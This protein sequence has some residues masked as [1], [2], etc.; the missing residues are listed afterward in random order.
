MNDIC[1]LFILNQEPISNSFIKIITINS[2]VSRT[3]AIDNFPIFFK[4][5]KINSNHLLTRRGSSVRL[6]IF[7]L[8]NESFRNDCCQKLIEFTN[9]DEELAR[10]ILIIHGYNLDQ[11]VDCVLSMTNLNELINFI[12]KSWSFFNKNSSNENIVQ[13]ATFYNTFGYTN[14]LIE[15]L[16]DSTY[17]K[18]FKL[19]VT[20]YNLIGHNNFKMNITVYIDR[21]YLN[22]IY[23][24]K[25]I[26]L[27]LFKIIEDMK[28]QK[29][30]SIEIKENNYYVHNTLNLKSKLKR[31]LY[32][33]QNHNINW[34]IELEYLIK[35]G[36]LNFKTFLND[37][38]LYIF[39]ID[40]IDDY[41]ICDKDGVMKNPENM[42]TI[43]IIPKGGLICDEVGLG[44]TFS[45][46]G[47]ISETYNIEQNNSNLIICPTRLCKQWSNEIDISLNLNSIIIS[48]ISQYKKYLKSIEK[49]NKYPII[50]ISYNFLTN[51]SYLKFKEDNHMLS[52]NFIENI[53]WERIILDEG[54]EYFNSLKVKQLYYRDT[55]V[56]LNKLKCNFKWVCSGTPFN[57]Y[58]SLGNLLN[59][60]CDFDDIQIRSFDEIKHI[61]QKLIDNITRKNTKQSVNS[62]IFIPD[63]IIETEFLNQTEIEKAIYQSSLGDKNKMIQLCSHVMVSE[64]HIT[65]LGN[66]PLAFNEIQIKMTQYYQ[67]QIIKTN[68]NIDNLNSKINENEE[69]INKYQIKLDNFVKKED[70]LL[71]KE[72][73]ETKLYNYEEKSLEYNIRLK[74][75]QDKLTENN[76]KLKIFNNLE[77]KLKENNECPVCLEELQS[78]VKVI[79]GC[80]HFICSNCIS[81]ILNKKNSDNCPY[82]R[83]TFYKDE[84]QIIKPNIKNDQE[85]NKWGTKMNYLISYLSDILADKNNRIIIFSQ[86]DNL[87]KLVGNVLTE[88]NILHL[89]LN[90]SIHV[91]NGRIRKFKLDENIRIVLLSS[92]KAVSGLTLTEANHIILLDTLNNDKESSRIIEQ[93]AIGRAVRIGQTKSVKVK[94][95][96][97]N[98]TI[99]YDFYLR[100]IE[101]KN[102]T[103]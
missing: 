18:Y 63:P 99:E 39:K 27:F 48:S 44:K 42:P 36:K 51:K 93:Q 4:V 81:K 49:K 94:R 19:H 60:I 33:Y 91:I 16:N 58:N 23:N 40:S 3:Y 88:K 5:E 87:L 98:D 41:F 15:L 89:F 61:G 102:I 43:N 6:S 12:D 45:F 31:E 62:E 77:K 38:N 100:N 50:I 35:K 53:L 79:L 76:S 29:P 22:N 72:T 70:K 28:V 24:F 55:L 21:I 26:P 82:C 66:K 71:S 54:H 7:Q 83:Q 52:N 25:N 65:I 34:M 20:H 37:S 47:L 103:I 8:I 14:G 84:L 59:F 13:I 9:I 1:D 78:N 2:K 68:Y 30:F 64:D 74:E 96:V 95:L 56:E 57:N 73:L 80:G 67:D 32:S 90:G 46:L 101:N 75:L 85:I 69:K 97:M 86:W 17:Q 10:K 11:S 92:E